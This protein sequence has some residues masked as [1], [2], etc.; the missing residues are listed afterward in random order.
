MKNNFLI[1]NNGNENDKIINNNTNSFKR[2]A[3]FIE[4][5]KEMEEFLKIIDKKEEKIIEKYNILIPD[6]SW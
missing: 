5:K 6:F 2:K 4:V 3:S 1:Q